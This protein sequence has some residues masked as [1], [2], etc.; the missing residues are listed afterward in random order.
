MTLKASRRRDRERARR[1]RVYLDG[2]FVERCF[3][4]DGRRGVVRYWLRDA[5]NRAVLRA[6]PKQ[7]GK[8]DLV[9]AWAEARGHV[10]WRETTA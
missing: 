7:N 6:V 1:T 5:E 10:A 9:P 4:A 8:F 2:R 3:Y